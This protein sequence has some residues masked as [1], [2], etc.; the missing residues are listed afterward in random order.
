LSGGVLR[1]VDLGAGG[2]TVRGDEAA[3]EQLF[4]NVLLNAAQALEADG[5][6]GVSV[7]VDGGNARVDIW[8]AGVGIDPEQLRSV[9]DPF[10][11][12]KREGTGLGLSVARQIVVAHGGAISIDSAV[13]AGTT[14]SIQLPLAV[15]EPRAQP[16][17][18]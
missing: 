16:G 17:N 3:L 11:S 13:E 1:P 9:F 18:A 5:E 15:A 10:M 7:A 2:L 8:D 6:A 12:T 14:V 4:L